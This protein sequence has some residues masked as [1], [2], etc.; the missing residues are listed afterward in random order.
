MNAGRSWLHEVL[1]AIDQV[2][3]ATLGGWS[4]ESISARSHRLG[5]RDELAGSWGRWR[6]VRAGVDALFMPQDVWIWIST[7]A[8]PAQRHCERAYLAEQA[9]LGMPPEYRQQGDA[10]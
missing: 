1:V 2:I 10:S 3:N 9:R 5:H 4:D 8:W 7:H 6:I